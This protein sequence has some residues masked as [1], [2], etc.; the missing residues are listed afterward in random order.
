MQFRCYYCGGNSYH[1]MLGD[2]HTV[3]CLSCGR[4]SKFGGRFD[5]GFV[6]PKCGT[7]S[8]MVVSGSDP[9]QVECLKCGSV[10]PF[11]PEEE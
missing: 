2:P 6:C 4:S 1:V 11:A 8:F 5:P 3:L 10:A 7:R 9:M